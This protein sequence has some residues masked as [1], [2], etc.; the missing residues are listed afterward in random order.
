MLRSSI[1]VAIVIVAQS[2]SAQSIMS[3]T[4]AYQSAGNNEIILLDIRSRE[5][6]N[7][8]GVGA[9][10]W[11][12]SMHEEAF[13]KKLQQILT[14]NPGKPIALICA[15][16][17]RSAHVTSI[18]ARNNITNVIDVSEGMH[19]SRRGAGWL[20]EALP[21]MSAQEALTAMPSNFRSNP[22]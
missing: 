2:A 4:Q 13:G 16:G 10:A 3:A 11:P 18:L 21:V 17:G 14:A 6:W 5:E 22:N 12:V 15:T 1:A 19:G 8:T 9:G 20:K 7:E